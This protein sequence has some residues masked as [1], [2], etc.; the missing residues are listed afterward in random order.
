M[1]IDKSNFKQT[2]KI[3]EDG[4]SLITG[5]HESQLKNSPRI[6]S[7]ED[8]DIIKPIDKITETEMWDAVGKKYSKFNVKVDDITMVIRFIP[9]GMAS[10]FVKSRLIHL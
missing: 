2:F 7:M 8:L 6:Y 3:S 1:I 4:L 5:K 10:L 9:S